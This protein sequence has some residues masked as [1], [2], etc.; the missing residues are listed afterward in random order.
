MAGRDPLGLRLALEADRA[1]S[2]SQA[3][4]W[5]GVRCKGPVPYG[6][7]LVWREIREVRRERKGREIRRG[8]LVLEGWEHLEGFELRHLAGLA[9]V[10]RKLGA[11]PEEWELDE[12]VVH[13]DATPDARWRTPR[14]V[15]AVEYDV[16]YDEQRVRKKLLGFGRAYAGIVWGAPTRRRVERLGELVRQVGVQVPV[17]LVEAPWL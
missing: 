1:I 7:S 8:F 3:E 2:C 11:A 13:Y 17:R 14:G 5:Y 10:R 16:G 9:A 4:R 12:T 15:W 6:V